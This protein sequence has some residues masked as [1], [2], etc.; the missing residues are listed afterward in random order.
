VSYDVKHH[1]FKYKLSCSRFIDSRLR[2][3]GVVQVVHIKDCVGIP[4]SLQWNRNS[5]QPFQTAAVWAALSAHMPVRQ[6]PIEVNPAIAGK[7]KYFA[8]A[9][10]V[11]IGQPVAIPPGG[12]AHIPSSTDQWCPSALCGADYRIK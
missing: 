6:P 11:G 10:I 1:V 8:E 7:M 3:F 9:S 4:H 12:R 5:E 2:G